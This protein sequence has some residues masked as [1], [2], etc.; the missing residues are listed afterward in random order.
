MIFSIQL[1]RKENRLFTAGSD[2]TVVCWNLKTGEPDG[3]FKKHKGSV[4]TLRLSKFK[5]KIFSGSIDQN[6]YKWDTRTLRV[7][8]RFPGFYTYLT[9][10]VFDSDER[11][12]FSLDSKNDSFIRYYFCQIFLNKIF[13]LWKNRVL[14]ARKC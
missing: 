14:K 10:L 3:V 9:A 13:R 1:N 4:Y 11:F 8:A 12:M 7:T 2:K 5:N 6:I